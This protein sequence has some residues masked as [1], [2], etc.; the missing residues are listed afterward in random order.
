MFEDLQRKYEIPP[1]SLHLV[2]PINTLVRQ[3]ITA[4]SPS[5]SLSPSPSHSI[6]F[7]QPS[8]LFQYRVP[9]IKASPVQG[10]S[11]FRSQINLPVK[12]TL[13]E[14]SPII[15]AQEIVHNH[16][17]P[18]PSRVSPAPSYAPPSPAPPLL[19]AKNNIKIPALCSKNTND[20]PSNI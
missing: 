15:Q 20:I 2:E 19:K 6:P 14:N 3:Q 10:M 8:P 5:P 12:Q 18:S 9:D 16:P 11:S 13:Y 7:I 4:P 17:S 1:T